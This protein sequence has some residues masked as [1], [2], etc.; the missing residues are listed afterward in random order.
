MDSV[1]SIETRNSCLI[2]ANN[3][4][5]AIH[6]YAI[7]Y[8]NLISGNYGVTLGYDLE[9]GSATD[10]AV[11]LG[12]WNKSMGPS[13]VLVIGTGSSDSTRNT[14]LRVT[15]VG[16]IFLGRAQGDMNGVVNGVGP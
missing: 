8:N 16:G 7:G 5:T 3:T 6:G 12:R 14:A 13:D 9:I 1:S 2:G 4:V 15:D 10:R 11:A